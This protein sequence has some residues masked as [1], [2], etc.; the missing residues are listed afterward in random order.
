MNATE[1]LHVFL[2]DHAGRRVRVDMELILKGFRS[3]HP[4]LA[5]TTVARPKLREMLD[6]LELDSCIELPKGKVGWDHTSLPPLPR[7]I[8][9]VREE[10]TDTEKAD[11]RAY[12]WAPELR[13]LANTRPVVPMDDLLKLQY[14]FA[15]GGR[16]RQPI[17]LKERSLQIFGDEKRLD[18]LFRGSSLFADERLTL[19]SLR[20]FV[21]PEPLAWERCPT[22]D[23]PI[24]VIE[25][26][27]TYHSYCQWN[28][29]RGFFS[30]VVYGCGNQLMH[31][32]S[33]IGKILRVIGDQPTVRYFGDLDPQG[34]RIARLAS[35]KSVTLGLP[36]I[37]PDLWSYRRLLELGCG[38]AT[39]A[40]EP[41]DC[42]E[43]DLTWLGELAGE[44]NK[45]FAQNRWLPQEHV[46]WEVL[47]P[48]VWKC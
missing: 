48:C 38:K 47:Q 45:L 19:E 8:R 18:A 5:T 2:L 43:Q 6:L 16:D 7:W 41:V 4:E 32:V 1:Q 17:P 46:N 30:A 39:V 13:F 3:V 25:N 28:R 40:A 27:A 36:P 42:D 34:L 11:L 31:S 21:V 10:V 20:C 12:P 22:S 23:G 35:A 14:F 26:A 9:L 37:E 24:M 29:T 44:A 33:Y 15:N